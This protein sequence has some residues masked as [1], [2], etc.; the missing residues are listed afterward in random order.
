ME[1]MKLLKKELDLAKQKIRLGLA[2]AL[3][4]VSGWANKKTEKM[5]MGVKWDDRLWRR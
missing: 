3:I 1:V 5:L 2:S 4:T